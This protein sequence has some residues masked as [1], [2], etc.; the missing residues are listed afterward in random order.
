MKTFFA[1]FAAIIAAVFAL[2]LLGEAASKFEQ[3]VKQVR[4][5]KALDAGSFFYNLNGCDKIT[6]HRT[7]N[8]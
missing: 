8:R 5:C 7:V 4:L 1:V 3:H 2:A 6:P